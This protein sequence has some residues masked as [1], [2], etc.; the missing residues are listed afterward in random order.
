[1]TSAS[2]RKKLRRR[3]RKGESLRKRSLSPTVKIILLKTM[4]KKLGMRKNGSATKMNSGRS[5]TFLM[6]LS[7]RA[8]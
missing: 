7:L 6:K 4:V 5:V 1:M 3:L 2:W 8:A